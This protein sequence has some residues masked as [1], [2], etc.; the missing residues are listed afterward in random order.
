M[1]CPHC[2]RKLAIRFRGRAFFITA[3]FIALVVCIFALLRG[4]PHFSAT[5]LLTRF[6]VIIVGWFLLEFA[7][8]VFYFSFATLV[9]RADSNA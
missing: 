2:R 9:P 1:R 5:T 3:V 4:W 8:A 7:T 6:S